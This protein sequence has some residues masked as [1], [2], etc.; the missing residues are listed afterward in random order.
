MRLYVQPPNQYTNGEQSG[1]AEELWESALLT[2]KASDVFVDARYNCRSTLHSLSQ[3]HLLWPKKLEILSKQVWEQTD[4][5][6]STSCGFW[7]TKF[8][9][10]RVRHLVIEG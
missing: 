10:L 5:V 7:V 6:L 4:T 3:Q 9:G 1:S 2:A 8:C